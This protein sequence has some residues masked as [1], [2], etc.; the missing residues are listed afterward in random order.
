MEIGC[1]WKNSAEPCIRIDEVNAL[2]NWVRVKNICS[3]DRN[4]TGIYVESDG[5]SRAE[6]EGSLC[7]RC[8]LTVSLTISKPL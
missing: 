6:L 2:G 3:S 4:L 5:R 8:T 7:P 1:L